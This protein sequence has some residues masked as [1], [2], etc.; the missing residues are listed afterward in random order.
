M[1]KQIIRLTESDLHNIVKESAEKIIKEA[2]KDDRFEYDHLSDEGNG[3]LEEY[4]M[5][6]ANLIL[7]LGT[8]SDSLHGLGEEVAQ[9]I[10]N[11][12]GDETTKERVLRPF[13]EGLIAWYKNPG[14]PNVVYQE[15]GI[16]RN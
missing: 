12:G 1:A 3:G 16:E 7:G 2:W 9:H 10:L 5:N 4:G 6:I 8:D 15:H 14:D 11:N 13:I